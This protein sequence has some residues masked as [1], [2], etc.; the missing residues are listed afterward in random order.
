MFKSEAFAQSHRVLDATLKTKKVQGLEPAVKHKDPLTAEDQEKVRTF[1]SNVL[2][3]ND[4]VKLTMF[5]WYTMTMHF[6]L[7]GHEV[8]VQL[9]KSD[10]KFKEDDSGEIVVLSTD[11]ASKNCPGGTAGRDMQRRMQRSSEASGRQGSEGC[12]R[13]GAPERIWS[14]W[15]FIKRFSKHKERLFKNR[16]SRRLH[17]ARAR[18][19]N[20]QLDYQLSSDP[21]EKVQ[22]VAT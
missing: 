6:R 11:F 4:P 1:F 8:Q 3:A 17:P 7:R 15:F 2:E 18:S 5:V 12:R 10:L 22:L 16:V 21:E 20:Q 14:G 13:C 9:N 19:Y